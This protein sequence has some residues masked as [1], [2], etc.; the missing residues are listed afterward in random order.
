MMYVILCISIWLL[1]VL[2]LRQC[3]LFTSFFTDFSTIES[4]S[5]YLLNVIVCSHI[6]AVY[7]QELNMFKNN[8]YKM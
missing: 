2:C 8:N 5:L 3:R 6:E 1:V 4:I 7:N